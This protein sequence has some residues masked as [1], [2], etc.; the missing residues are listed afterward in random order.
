MNKKET[1]T[2]TISLLEYSTL[3]AENAKLKEKL[4]MVGVFNETLEEYRRMRDE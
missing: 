1:T 3:V 2:I 4:R